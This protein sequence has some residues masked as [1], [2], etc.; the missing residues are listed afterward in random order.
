MKIF[1]FLTVLGAVYGQGY[2]NGGD[3]NKV[4]FNKNFQIL[5]ILV[6]KWNYK[7]VAKVAMTETAVKMAHF[8]SI[9][10]MAYFGAGNYHIESNTLSNAE[11][12]HF[13]LVISEIGPF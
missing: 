10:V 12:A 4:K 2:G 13:P 8:Y 3:D 11:M 5:K 9:F 7:R 6:R 1:G